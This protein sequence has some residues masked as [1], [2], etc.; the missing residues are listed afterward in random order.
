MAALAAAAFAYVTAEGLPIG[1]LGPMARG[2]HTSQSDIGLLVTAYAAVAG[3]AAIP[4]TWLVRRLDRRVIALAAVA[5]LTASQVGMAAAPSYG[6]ALAARLV[7]ALAHGVFWSVL[8][9]V[10]GRL[11]SPGRAGRATATVFVGNSVALVAGIPLSSAVGRL[12]GWRSAMLLMAGAGA[13]IVVWL[14]R[15]VP[16]LP[17]L[18]TVQDGAPGG[19]RLGRL[20]AGSPALALLCLATAVAVTGHFTAY[21]YITPLVRLDGGLGGLWV[22]AALLAY[23]LA[24]VAGIVAV[25]KGVDRSPATASVGCAVA[26]VAAMGALAALPG[27]AAGSPGPVSATFAAVAVWG[28]GFTALPVGLQTTVLRLAPHRADLASALY[29]VAF[30]VGIGGGALVGAPLVAA[31][32]L[33]ALPALGAALAA[34]AV[35]LLALTARAARREAAA[36]A[37]PVWVGGSSEAAVLAARGSSR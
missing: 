32:D 11:A 28:A 34:V 6:T 3:A 8:A 5:V 21:T 27:S 30:Q 13:G 15:T 9:P 16:P 25:G 31:G 24:G 29:V 19:H 17:A 14:A 23:G 22:P 18:A 36:P 12:L 7:C 33:R 37:P 1:L 20:G 10:A 4:V 26:L 2:L 35:V